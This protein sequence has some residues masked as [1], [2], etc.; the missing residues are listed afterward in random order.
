MPGGNT[1]EFSQYLEDMALGLTK[2]YEN[3]LRMHERSYTAFLREEPVSRWFDT[4]WMVSGFGT[5]PEKGIGAAVTTDR[6]MKSDTKQYELQAYSLGC[7]IDYEAYRWDLYGIFK[8]LPAELAKSATDRYNVVGHSLLNNSFSAPNSSYQ[9]YNGENMISTAHTRLDGGVWS[10][11]IAGNPGLGYLGVQQGKILMRKLVNERGLYVKMEPRLLITSVDNEWIAEEITR[12]TSRP[13][14]SNP[15]VYSSTRNFST[16]SSPYL[17]TPQYW[18]LEANKA[19]VNIGMRMGDKPK[20]DRD[21]DVRSKALV[22][23]SYCSFGVKV[24][25]SRGLIGSTGGA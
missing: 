4:D 3:T 12:S 19:E 1:M 20:L 22:M 21:S 5:M 2:V 25:D 9:I 23:T 14:Q 11:Q 13:D 24:F 6:I 18:W 15:A 17:T 10:N 16:Y 7:T 8:N